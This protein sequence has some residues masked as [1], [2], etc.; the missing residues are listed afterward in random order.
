MFLNPRIQL[1]TAAPAVEPAGAPPAAPAAPPASPKPVIDLADLTTEIKQPDPLWDDLMKVSGAIA[2][3][4]EPPVETPAPAP[5]ADP[6]PPAQAPTA[7]AA[8]A[9]PATP[10][11]KPRITIEPPKAPAS[12]APAPAPE[13]APAA[14]PA[15]ETL[16]LSGL[17][18]EQLTEIQEAQWAEA[19]IPGKYPKLASRMVSWHKA[20][21][22]KTAEL[23]ARGEKPEDNEEYQT[24][25][26]SR[27]AITQVDLRRVINGMAEASATRKAREEV[28]REVAPVRRSQREMELRPEIERVHKEMAKHV[29]EGF[30]A[31]GTETEL[32]KAFKAGLDKATEEFP[33]EATLAS[34]Q[35]ARGHEAAQEYLLIRNGG[36]EYDQNNETHVWL[37]NFISKNADWF[38][39]NAGTALVRDGKSFLTPAQYQAMAK[40]GKDVSGN[41]TFNESDVLGFLVSNVRFG[42]KKEIELAE[43]RAA[44]YK[45]DQYEIGEGGK[46]KR[47]KPAAATPP[48]VTPP[49]P[50]APIAPPPTVRAA[51]PGAV[52]APNTVV[53]PPGILRVDDLTSEIKPV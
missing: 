23:I 51:A 29:L 1:N 53:T 41:W 13:P 20:N 46:F 9:A 22:E 45:L 37:G 18:E 52:T 3:A 50:A 49:A 38:A 30:D 47:R 6:T 34:E 27:P 33:L 7:P 39:K 42:I 44:H 15:P 12:P 21:D 35:I 25:L 32:G 2:P 48:P 4:P 19:N 43:K 36:R 24:F 26:K 14:T 17:N 5:P 40:A 8:P 10:A 11:P 31:D 16:D 28:E